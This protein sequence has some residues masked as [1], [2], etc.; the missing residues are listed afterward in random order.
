[1]LNDLFLKKNGT[2]KHLQKTVSM[3]TFII[4][5]IRVKMTQLGKLQTI[6]ILSNNHH[7]CM[8]VMTVFFECKQTLNV[9]QTNIYFAKSTS[10]TYMS[11]MYEE[12]KQ[13]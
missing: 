3:A 11:T 9:L 12:L 1:M 6:C 13:L 2:F 10:L 7:S 5:E 8:S 4:S